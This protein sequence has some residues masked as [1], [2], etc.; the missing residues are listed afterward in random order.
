MYD[1]IVFLPLFGFLIAG[2]SGASSARAARDRHHRLPDAVRRAFLDRLLQ[3]ASA[4]S[5]S[6]S[7][8]TL[9][10]ILRRTASGSRW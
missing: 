2:A 3:S 10:S 6:M 9:E 4:T 8:R 5:R 7:D 1:L